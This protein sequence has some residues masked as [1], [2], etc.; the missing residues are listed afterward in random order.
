MP[1]P[2]AARVLSAEG[3]ACGFRAEKNDF[4]GVGVGVGVGDA[5]SDMAKPIST[6]DIEQKILR[7]II[8]LCS[9]NF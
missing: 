1:R 6:I 5:L 2:T 9:H 8:Q 7:D 4:F 3:F